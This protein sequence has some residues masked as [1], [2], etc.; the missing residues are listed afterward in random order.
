MSLLSAADVASPPAAD[1][2]GAEDGPA[3][4]GGDGESSE[5]PIFEFQPLFCDLKH[6]VC[7]LT[8]LFT[9][10]KHNAHKGK[11]SEEGGKI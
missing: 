10:Y 1:C 8:H 4:G 5:S 3:A 9:N 6:L 11:E 2:P 7:S